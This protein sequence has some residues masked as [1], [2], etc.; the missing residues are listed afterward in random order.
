MVYDTSTYIPRESVS[1]VAKMH[2]CMYV[3]FNTTRYILPTRMN[4]VS[5]HTWYT[6][7]NHTSY[8][9]L[10][11]T[12]E[13]EQSINISLCIPYTGQHKLIRKTN[14]E[15][16]NNENLVFNFRPFYEILS[17]IRRIRTVIMVTFGIRH[18]SQYFVNSKFH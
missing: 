12:R 17:P 8:M 11:T 14:D 1:L 10:Y 16:N 4:I 18:N 3:L 9:L 5:Y 7:I 13:H 2:V 15:S 6:T